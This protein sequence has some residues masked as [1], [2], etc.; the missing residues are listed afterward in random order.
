MG[1][2]E[3]KLCRDGNQGH[4]QVDPVPLAWPHTMPETYELRSAKASYLLVSDALQI[5]A[6]PV[7]TATANMAACTLCTPHADKAIRG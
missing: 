4:V 3:V 5:P 6:G 2:S 1:C 7:R